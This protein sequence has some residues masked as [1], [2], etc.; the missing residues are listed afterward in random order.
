MVEAWKEF[1]SIC[2]QELI[3]LLDKKI[4]ATWGKTFNGWKTRENVLYMCIICDIVK[5]TKKNKTN[6][7]R[8]SRQ[9]EHASLWSRAMRDNVES[10]EIR[11]SMKQKCPKIL[12]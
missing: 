1:L 3:V 4:H 9:L 8:C 11:P 7:P 2:I 12:S 10:L 5:F 6:I